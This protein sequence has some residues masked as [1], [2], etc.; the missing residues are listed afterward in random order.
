MYH[1]FVNNSTPEIRTPHTNQGTPFCPKGVQIRGITLHI[2][3]THAA[4]ADPVL[5]SNNLDNCTYVLCTNTS[6]LKTILGRDLIIYKRTQENESIEVFLTRT[7]IGEMWED[8]LGY[9]II[10]ANDSGWRVFHLDSLF[11]AH[12]LRHICINIYVRVENDTK[13]VSTERL[14]EIFVVEPLFPHEEMYKPFSAVFINGTFPISLFKKRS[15]GIPETTRCGNTTDCVLQKHI[16]NLQ[17]RLST[18]VILPVEADLGNCVSYQKTTQEKEVDEDRLLDPQCDGLQ[19]CEPTK[20]EDLFV[21]VQDDPSLVLTSL[22]DFI[23]TEC[24]TQP[25]TE[26]E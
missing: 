6:S 13:F 25:R 1:V 20:F 5:P 16:I 10:E 15:A 8:F 26:M 21:L 11:G 24:G 14:K 12:T 9:N 3:A 19:R 2:F 18:D 17:N 23:T 7:V 4:P 22:P